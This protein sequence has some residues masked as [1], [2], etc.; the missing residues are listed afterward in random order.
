MKKGIIGVLAIAIILGAI[1]FIASRYP[2]QK[3]GA[4]A[5]AQVAKGVDGLNLNTYTKDQLVAI[6]NCLVNNRNFSLQDCVDMVVNN[7]K[8]AQA[9]VTISSAVPAI[10]P[11]NHQIKTFDVTSNVPMLNFELRASSNSASIVSVSVIASGTMPTALHLYDGT[12]LISSRTG[13]GIVKFENIAIPIAKGAKKTLTVK[14]DFGSNI[15]SGSVAMVGLTSIKYQRSN[16]SLVEITPSN[17]FYAG[18]FQ[19]LYTAGTNFT[20]AS[21][22]TM[23]TG[24][25]QNGTGSRIMAN[26]RVLTTPFGGNMD[27]PANADVIV[28]FTDGSNSFTAP[29]VGI[30]VD[31]GMTTI[32]EGTTVGLNIMAIMPT[33]PPSGMY[34]AQIAQIRWKVGSQT[35]TQTWGFDGTLSSNS[36][37]WNK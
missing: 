6:I 25:Q 18:P 34:K 22:T 17:N 33:T 1:I 16:G 3:S 35:V 10:Q 8:P 4:T 13:A 7:Q 26:I 30:T 29:A 24:V 27:I 36:A 2:F 37:V 5:G 12:T 28:K 15:P 20:P 31:G 9:I 19:H 21:S 11:Q 14:A 23:T 32:S